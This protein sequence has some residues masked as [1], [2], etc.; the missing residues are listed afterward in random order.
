MEELMNSTEKYQLVFVSAEVAP[1]SQTGGL[2]AVM[3]G[4]PT[5]LA[6]RGHRV[7][8]VAPRYDQYAD[9]WDTS[10]RMEVKMGPVDT[11]VGYFHT[12]KQKVDRVWVD[13]SAFLEKVWGLTKEKLYGPKWGKDFDDNQARFSMFA[14][15]V[16]GAIKL[17]PLGGYPYGEDVIILCNDWHSSL[18][19]LYLDYYRQLEPGSWKTTKTIFVSHNMVYQGRFPLRADHKNILNLPQK[20]ID[21]MSCFMPLKVGRKHPKVSCLNWMMGAFKYSD[22]LM[23]V[24]PGYSSEILAGPIKGVELDE[25]AGVHKGKMVGILNGL[26]DNVVPYNKEMKTKG[27]LA[28]VYTEET[29]E[30][31]LICKAQ[32]QKKFDLPVDPE[33]PVFC[34]LGRYDVQ[35]GIDIM[36]EAFADG[37]LDEQ[38]FQVIIMGSG[39]EEL[40][41]KAI[42]LAEKYP[43]KF[44][45]VLQFKGAEK[46][47]VFAG[48]DYA[49]VPSRYEPCG[50][51]QMEAMRMGTIP[52]VSPT[53]GLNDT[54]VDGETGLIL[55]R[56]LDPES[57][58]L[59]EDVDVIKAGIIRAIE[60][61]KDSETILSMRRSGMKVS[62]GFTWKKAA[63]EY[64]ALFKS[65]GGADVSPIS[66]LELGDTAAEEKVV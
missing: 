65:I 58:V 13:H 46:Y 22:Q 24:S 55:E 56:E 43:D 32:L 33:I 66:V 45:A 4:L 16:L 51:V 1:W 38:E 9:A 54:V 27:G 10:V 64:E 14:Q 29:L 53:G 23:T 19:P 35:K 31:K 12:Y 36:F 8:S 52:V 42:F 3:D 44:K 6:A 2:G 40:V 48:A 25:L 26:K 50:L 21:D 17:I 61:F 60:V 18:V 57:E 62:S 30:R 20:Y 5:T 39:T 7:M 11:E 37:L 34:F 47:Q 15:A 49:L 59:P 28:T 41:D 63:Q